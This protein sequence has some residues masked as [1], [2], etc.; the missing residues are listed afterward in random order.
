MTSKIKQITQILFLA[1]FIFL[2]ALGKVQMWMFIFL[3]S[4]AAAFIFGRFYCGWLCP[5]NTLTEGVNWLYK[6]LGL[7]RKAV[8]AG[9]KTPVIR[10]GILALF[11]M[12]LVFTMVMGKKIPVLLILT[13]VGVILTLFFTPALWH[14]YLC[15]YGTLLG[16]TGSFAKFGYRIDNSQCTK[17]GI[18]KAVC[19]G[20]AVEMESRKD[21]PK[22]ETSLC[23]ECR[24]CVEKCPKD[25]IKY[26]GNKAFNN[27]SSNSS[28]QV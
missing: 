4:V 8:P 21:F 9:F 1:A 3:G 11:V 18:C 13:I 22:I 5:T 16:F 20:E 15:P 19:P 28:K 25:T 10:Y 24:A 17:C 12:T 6:K 2:V 14:R 27:V 7:K 23:L 26:S